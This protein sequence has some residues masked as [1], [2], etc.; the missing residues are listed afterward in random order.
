MCF[1]P[2]AGSSAIG[3]LH[4]EKEVERMIL[5]GLGRVSGCLDL[6]EESAEGKLLVRSIVFPVTFYVPAS[7]AEPPTLG[8]LGTAPGWQALGVI[9]HDMNRRSIDLS[10]SEKAEIYDVIAGIQLGRT[11]KA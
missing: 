10:P 7:D 6:A 1:D 8:E 11:H 9:H 4:L 5:D 3:G 2:F